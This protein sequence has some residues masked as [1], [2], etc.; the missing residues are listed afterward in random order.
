MI[1]VGLVSHSP[2]LTGAE[3]MLLNLGI[4]LRK[5]AAIEPVLFI[6]MSGHGPLAGEA[7]RNNITWVD[8]PYYRWYIFK[9]TENRELVENYCKGLNNAVAALRKIFLENNLDLLFN[10]TLTCINGL[11]AAISL[12]IP[13]ITWVHGILDSYLFD[14]YDAVYR[15]MVD[16]AVLQLSQRII[17]NSDWTKRFFSNYAPGEKI[18]TIP[19][20]TP[21]PEGGVAF[22]P[23][24]NIFVC[25]NTFDHNK[26]IATLIEAVKILKDRNYQFMVELYGEGG[27]K[28][29]IV[30][31]VETLNLSNCIQFKGRTTD[32]GSVYNRCLA[33]LQPSYI[34]SFGMTILEAMTY[35]RA[36]I[37]AKSGGPQEIIRDGVN[38]LLVDPGDAGQMA[39]KMAYLLEHKDV[40]RDLGLMG[41]KTYREKYTGDIAA[42]KFM[43]TITDALNQ[44]SG[45]SREQLLVYDLLNWVHY[46]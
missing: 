34:E 45:Y 24:S 10:N 39:D 5:N 42:A 15:M 9:P 19:N 27:E 26:G 4:A 40:A 41:E 14:N 35:Q 16:R 44:F 33:L 11:L 2:H 23:A 36:V 46:R 31:R 3:K 30:R 25:L 18:V 20:W 32:T 28:E 6:P 43:T 8:I 12:Q 1:R 29:N 22:Y 38:G 13:V 37:A 17:C 21:D 7:R